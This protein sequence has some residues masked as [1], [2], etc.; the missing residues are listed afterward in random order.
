MSNQGIQQERLECLVAELGGILVP[1]LPMGGK[2]ICRLS[3]EI[4]KHCWKWKTAHNYVVQ[5]IL[6]VLRD[7]CDL[8]HV[9]AEKNSRDTS[10]AL[11]LRNVKFRLNNL[12]YRYLRELP[13]A[14]AFD[15]PLED[16]KPAREMTR[17]EMLDLGVPPEG[18]DLLSPDGC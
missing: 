8:L 15:D 3:R 13:S 14:I 4:H 10:L 11:Y 5:R 2:R 16:P 1:D 7:A 9:M 12:E 17:Q 6:P 18:L